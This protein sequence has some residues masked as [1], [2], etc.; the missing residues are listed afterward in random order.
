[1]KHYPHHFMKK[2]LPLFGMVVLFTLFSSCLPSEVEP[3]S[4][5]SIDP[6]EKFLGTWHVSDNSSRLNYDVVITR[7]SSQPQSKVK[8]SNFA[9]LGG[10]I[11]GEV[12]G[13]T[14]IISN[15]LIGSSDYT[16]KDGTGTYIDATRIDFTYTLDD[17]I[18]TQVRNAV[19][20]K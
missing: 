13:N 11:D 20:T 2:I 5:G 14:I 9:G 15:Q 10:R 7:N 18:D 1:M 16:V 3:T 12:V 17:G 6:A 8:L 4:G 19:F